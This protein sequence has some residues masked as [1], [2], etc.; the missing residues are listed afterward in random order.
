MSYDFD[1][2]I[3]RRQTNSIKIDKM[4]LIFGRDDLQ[5]LWVADMDFA[6]PGFILNDLKERLNHPVLGYT[7][8]KSGFYQA[9]INWADKR[10]GWN[11][12]ENWLDFSPGVVGALAISILALTKENDKIIIQPP[13]YHPFFDVVKGN[14][15]Q[16]I[17]NPLVRNDKGD[18]QMDFKHLRSLID[19]QT[20]M[21]IIANPHNPVG[22]VWTKQELE[23]LGKIAV[24]ND[25]II[26]SDDIHADFI[27]TGNTYTPLASIDET[28]AR[29]TVTVM[30]PSKTFNIAGLSTSVVII[31]N[32]NLKNKYRQ[33]LMDMHLFL[34]NIFGN[35][36]F[37]SAY[38]KGENWL[39]ELLV[40]LENNRNYIVDFLQKNIP[41]IKPVIPEGT[42]LMWLDFSATGLTHQQIKDKLINQAKL[43]LNDG[44]S[45][46]K[47]GEKYFRFNFAT[48]LENIKKALEKLKVFKS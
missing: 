15:R 48:P 35:I 5:P 6:T 45:F 33:K 8:R 21:I 27:Y 13:V 34:G 24:E 10:Y 17:E 29:Q 26:V 30:A 32:E 39:K 20:K 46:G 14:N 44:L 43:A 7:L 28:I 4:P 22:R 18:Y 12:K 25:L 36:A 40:Y 31:P 1:R 41:D 16:L 42:F 47:N 23:T 11:L 9:F 38:N 37:E 2:I 3:D 19:T